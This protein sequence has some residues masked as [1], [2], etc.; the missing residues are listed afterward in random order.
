MYLSADQKVW[1]LKAKDYLNEIDEDAMILVFLRAKVEPTGQMFIKKENF[2]LDKPELD[3][4]VCFFSFKNK[5]ITP[6]MYNQSHVLYLPH[7]F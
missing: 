2:P 6:Q 7:L 3:I 5:Y 1:T 4:M